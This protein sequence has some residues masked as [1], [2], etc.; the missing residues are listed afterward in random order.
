MTD[1]INVL[2]SDDEIIDD[3]LA[4]ATD[5]D[6]YAPGSTAEILASGVDI[7]G[8]VTFKID[9]VSGPGEDGIYGTADDTIVDLGGDGHESWSVT[10]GG[11]GDLDGL[12]NGS[13]TTQWYV[14]PDDSL[15]ETFILAATSETDVAYWSF[16][17]SLP[18]PI[19]IS[20]VESDLDLTALDSP[21][22]QDESGA[23]WT[24]DI[25]GAGTGV[26][27]PFVRIQ[28]TG[29]DSSQDGINTSGE[30]N[31]DEK[32]QANGYTRDLLL[33]EVALFNASN[34]EVLD[35]IDPDDPTDDFAGNFYEFRLDINENSNAKGEQYISLDE[36]MIF[37]STEANLTL[38]SG[39]IV[40]N[41]S[42]TDLTNEL[43]ATNS[44]D[45]SQLALVYDLDALN[46]NWVALNYD[47]QAG[48]GVG[49]IALYI[50]Q[51]DFTDAI[52]LLNDTD[53]G[54]TF[55][56]TASTT[57]VYLI[58]SMGAEGVGEAP[59][60][61]ADDTYANSGQTQAADWGISD[62]FEEWS[63]LKAQPFGAIQG[64]KYQDDN[65][66]GILN[67][68]ESGISGW[69]I[70]LYADANGDGQFTINDVYNVDG[71]PISPVR[72]SQT[73][74]LEAAGGDATLVGS[75]SFDGVAVGDYWLV[76]QNFEGWFNSDENSKTFIDPL[77]N[78]EVLF[79][80]SDLISVT[81]GD[82]I[83]DT[84]AERETTSFLNYQ[85]VAIS[86][87]K[88]ED[89]D[90]D[91]ATTNDQ[92]PLAGVTIYLFFADGTPVLGTGGNQ[93]TAVTG[94]DGKYSFTDL[95]PGDYI[96]S[97]T[98]TFGDSDDGTASSV[99][100]GTGETAKTYYAVDDI[101]ETGTISL[102]SG[103]SSDTNDFL[104][105]QKVAISG[106][107]YE[108]G[109]ADAATTN[110]Q[111][112]LAGVTIYLFFA[113]GTPVLG[114]GGNQLTA[115]TGADGKYSFTD[116][117][118]GDYIVSETDT[119]GD[120][121]D[122][123][124]S[125]VTVGT[126][127]TAKTYY[128][129]DDITE[130]GTISLASGQSSDTNDFLNYEAGTIQGYKFWDMDRSGTW[131]FE[132]TNNNGVR[133]DEEVALAGGEAG[134]KGW[135]I[136]LYQDDG[137][138]IFNEITPI[139][140][141]VSD[142]TGFWS[143]DDLE[144]G[145]YF[146]KEVLQPGYVQTTPDA[147]GDG[148]FKVEISASGEVVLS[149]MAGDLLLF[150]NDMIDGPG[151]RTPGFWQSKLG[152]TFW[153]GDPADDGDIQDRGIEKTGD[154]FA[155]DDVIVL[156][157]GE[158]PDENTNP[159]EIPPYWDLIGDGELRLLIG[160]WD[161]S[162]V[163]EGDEEWYLDGAGITLV[164]ALNALQG[165]GLD[166]EKNR[167]KDWGKTELIER[168]LVASWL[169]VMAGND[170]NMTTP[171]GEDAMYWID[172]AIYYL[173]G[174]NEADRGDK[175]AAWGSGVRYDSDNDGDIDSDDAF[176]ESGSDIHTALDGWNNSGDLYAFN[177]AFDGDNGGTVS[178]QSY[179]SA[180]D[181]YEG[182][183]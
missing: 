109:D 93:L 48:S 180:E 65:A 84:D 10:D 13:I 12:E 15:D 171:L 96:V 82:I 33:S 178:A 75:Y 16:T 19:G 91:A 57:Y 144:M 141:T 14:N 92:T 166:G 174:L 23:V 55:D 74:T 133:D 62:G 99:T 21:D 58:S 112:P 1:Q 67:G 44:L 108:D 38:S 83:G 63:V 132:D 85:K 148:F 37:V 147:F 70:Y 27:S 155:D 8:T 31:N 143:F 54:S 36:V 110:D 53:A 25:F 46:D 182:V 122:G 9:H 90:A 101:T 4:V 35:G 71:T 163:Q 50:K 140:T 18:A 157:Y 40:D 165:N 159:D 158:Q 135:T 32:A 104:N 64:Y 172:Q 80:H 129:V 138:E 73:L 125:S 77:T 127:E 113:D 52:S 59:E 45:A 139:R 115:V 121:D 183:A 88:Y 105:Y 26:I 79:V 117:D 89:G 68:D 47:L 103:Q 176:T 86:G 134:A 28:A 72:Q 94:A 41:K 56:G 2:L 156:R 153:N 43:L 76:E 120:S 142:E 11:E 116:L 24:N 22:Y 160:D 161:W 7:G 179:Y 168:D 119:F 97:E 87:I 60:L 175:K 5:L 107:K 124:A 137:D 149:D 100:V 130:T 78:E 128:A 136:E 49:D 69:H 167:G 17:D 146:V 95:D 111:T 106:I 81:T 118:P 169:N 152:Q 51:S 154:E 177:V 61:N 34:N 170:P 29:N 150:G 162:A 3:G 98:D 123:T 102:A 164:E 66:D 151:V 6:D 39:Y 42:S 181:Q 131:D 20:Q 126:G 114:T 30:I 145:I 173:N